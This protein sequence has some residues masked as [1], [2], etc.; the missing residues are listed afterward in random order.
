MRLA[1][2]A[3]AL[4]VSTSAFADNVDQRPNLA[5]FGAGAIVVKDAQAYSDT[6]SGFWLLDEDPSTGYAPPKGDLAPK[7]FVVELADIDALDEVSF[8]VSH[9]ESDERAVK[10]VT[11]EIA[12][13]MAG[14]FAAFVTA[15]VAPGKDNQRVK[16]PK[17]MTGRYL[18]ITLKD[19]HGSPD[20][21]ELMGVG[22]YG[23][24][25]TK[26]PVMDYTGMYKTSY[27]DFRVKA[28]GNTAIGCYEQREG[29]IRNGG[30]DGRV[31]RFTWEEKAENGTKGGPAVLVFP[32]DGKTFLG[33]WWNEGET[34]LGGRWDGTFSKKALGV[35]PHYKFTST[36]R[37]ADELKAAGRVRLYGITFD[38]DSDHIKD[39][40][41]PTLDLL[42]AAAKAEPTWKLGIEGHTDSTGTPEHNQTLSDKRAASVK[43]Y[44]VK[45]G[46][47]ADRLTTKGFGATKPV[48]TND[49]SLG[50]SQN[51]RVEVAKN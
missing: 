18:R 39:E 20:Y 8:D 13:K 33:L 21:T 11:V 32:S 48:A 41:K 28:T 9:A 24:V 31:L 16:A 26:Q 40:S 6:W 36:N 22:A 23:K 49:T 17:A 29:M 3:L 12:D 34:T 1:V 38:T 4:V 43:T 7:Q 44:L 2:A 5:S 14:P 35:C 19:N 27:G 15:T 50:R 37:V 45:A 42:I 51:R 46:I 25:V 47:A 30:F 10:T